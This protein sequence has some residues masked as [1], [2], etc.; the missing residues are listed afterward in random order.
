MLLPAVLFTNFSSKGRRDWPPRSLP[1]GRLL[2][3]TNSF[4]DCHAGCWVGMIP[5]SR[6]PADASKLTNSS[7]ERS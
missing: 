3:A 4:D 6:N 1:G 2:L 7:A 5:V